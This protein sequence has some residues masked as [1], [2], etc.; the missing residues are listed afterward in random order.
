MRFFVFVPRPLCSWFLSGAWEEFV[1]C[2]QG[3]FD[4]LPRMWE[5]FLTS[6]LSPPGC[7]PQVPPEVFCTVSA[8]EPALWWGQLRGVGN[9]RGASGSV[10]E[11]ISL[12]TFRS[13]FCPCWFVCSFVRGISYLGDA[14]YIFVMTLLKNWLCTSSLRPLRFHFLVEGWS[15]KTGRIWP[16]TH[17]SWGQKE[18]HTLTSL[19]CLIFLRSPQGDGGP[20]QYPWTGQWV[21]GTC[22]TVQVQGP[23]QNHDLLM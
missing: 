18:G 8:W 12:G 3:L 1:I 9:L 16:R 5:A 20:K 2:K 6:F 11:A 23:A 14:L 10:R 13:G 19:L 17:P 15:P 21:G 22:P 7:D 4:L